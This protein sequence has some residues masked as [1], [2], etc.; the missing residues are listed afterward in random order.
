M[1]RLAKKKT[2]IIKSETLQNSKIE[3]TM[4]GNNNK[5]ANKEEK[6]PME[7]LMQK[8][9]GKCNRSFEQKNKRENIQKMNVTEKKSQ[10]KSWVKYTTSLVSL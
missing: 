6:Y 5:D 4:K 7:T 1:Q 9:K 8:E 2:T 10:R 3:G